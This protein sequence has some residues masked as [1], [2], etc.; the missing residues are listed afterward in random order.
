M[1]LSFDKAFGVHQYTIGVREKRAEVLSENIVNADTP[2]YKARDIDF[3]SM[4]S[5]AEGT[6][7]GSLSLSKTNDL[8]LDGGS[9]LDVGLMYRIP[10]QPDTGD[11]NTVDTNYERTEYTRNSIEHQ[12]SVEF[13]NSKITSLMKALKGD[14]A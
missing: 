7:S 11:G 3:S 5:Q 9:S 6:Q 8:H 12:A 10:T 1:A 14:S 2:G 13:L 4:L